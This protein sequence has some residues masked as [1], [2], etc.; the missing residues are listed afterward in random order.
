MIIRII[1]GAIAVGFGAY[2]FSLNWSLIVNR[3]A[4]GTLIPLLGGA[5]MTGGLLL[6]S[7]RL[8]WVVYALP[9]VLDLGGVPSLAYQTVVAY[10]RGAFKGPGDE[11]G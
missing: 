1:L 11:G 4:R 3:K 6:L 2:I 8:H 10:R 9:L 7:T 5:L